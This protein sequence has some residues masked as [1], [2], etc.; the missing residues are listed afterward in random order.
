MRAIAVAFLLG[1][2][3]LVAYA[4]PP[5]RI[6]RPVVCQDTVTLLEVVQKEWGEQAMLVSKNTSDD[7]I[8]A[9]YVNAQTGALTVI[10]MNSQVACIIG[11]GQGARYRLPKTDSM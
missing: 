2:T 7:T 11:V 10:E 5:I 9:V 8:V 1:L 4:A 6:N 3:H